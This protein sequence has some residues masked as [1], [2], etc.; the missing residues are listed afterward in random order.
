MKYCQMLEGE[1]ER[2]NHDMQTVISP[3]A[4]CNRE[5][6]NRISNHNGC[7]NPFKKNDVI[8]DKKCPH[9]C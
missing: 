4:Y 5:T 7:P 8:D 2:W 6:L 1:K 3:C 9:C